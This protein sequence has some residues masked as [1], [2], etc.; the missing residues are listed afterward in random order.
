M[1]ANLKFRRILMS[2]I[3]LLTACS[4]SYAETAVFRCS[5]DSVTGQ[6]VDSVTGAPLKNATVVAVWKIAFAS[7]GG[8]TTSGTAQIKIAKT[9]VSGNFVID[10][11]EGRVLT[12]FES[13]E[14]P[15]FMVLKQDYQTLTFDFADFQ[16]L[17]NIQLSYK[18][19]MDNFGKKDP[20]LREW[21]DTVDDQIQKAKNVGYRDQIRAIFE[22]KKLNSVYYSG[23]F[24][25]SKVISKEPWNLLSEDR[26]ISMLL[27]D[28]YGH[29][30]M[31]DDPSIA[32]S[33]FSADIYTEQEEVI[34]MYEMFAKSPGEEKM[35]KYMDYKKDRISKY[36]TWMGNASQVAEEVAKQNARHKSWRKELEFLKTEIEKSSVSSKAIKKKINLL[37]VSNDF[38]FDNKFIH[39]PNILSTTGNPTLFRRL[40]HVG[41]DVNARFE[42]DYA[43]NTTPLMVQ[44][45]NGNLRCVQILL[46]EGAD[47]NAV[48]AFGES[49]LFYATNLGSYNISI[50]AALLDAGAD[51]SLETIRGDKAVVPTEKLNAFY[52]ESAESKKIDLGDNVEVGSITFMREKIKRDV[53]SFLPPKNEIIEVS[54]ISKVEL[55]KKLTEYHDDVVVLNFF[56][57]SELKKGK[58]GR[59]EFLFNY[60][61]E[62]LDKVYHQYENS[63]VKVIGLV[64]DE[65]YDECFQALLYWKKIKYPLYLLIDDK[66]A[67]EKKY[68]MDKPVYALYKGKTIENGNLIGVEDIVE[69]ILPSKMAKW[70]ALV[71]SFPEKSSYEKIVAVIVDPQASVSD[72]QY[73]LESINGKNPGT[74][75]RKRARRSRN[76]ADALAEMNRRASEA[77]ARDMATAARRLKRGTR[78]S[79]N[80]SQSNNVFDQIEDPTLLNKAILDILQNESHAGLRR[81]AASV[82]ASLANHLS[83]DNLKQ[84]LEDESDVDVFIILCNVLLKKDS[85][86]T[87]NYLIKLFADSDRI[88]KIHLLGCF[89]KA[90]QADI[91]KNNPDF[92]ITQVT[93]LWN[94]LISA[95]IK[96]MEAAKAEKKFIEYA[97]NI[98]E[99]VADPKMIP[100]HLVLL[101]GYKEKQNAVDSMI[102]KYKYLTGGYR[103]RLESV[104]KDRSRSVADNAERFL[105]YPI[106]SYKVSNPSTIDGEIEIILRSF[107]KYSAEGITASGYKDKL[108]ESLVN[109]LNADYNPIVKSR[110]ISLFKVMG[111]K[112]DISYLKSFLKHDKPLVRN[113]ALVPQAARDAIQAITGEGTQK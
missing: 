54:E 24:K 109:I 65:N 68:N 27:S 69:D 14:L 59:K 85:P 104:L 34:P 82:L 88:K 36:K 37:G 101:D 80:K 81:A 56:K 83:V 71:K 107:V 112:S 16:S 79:A 50:I 52:A 102:H 2:L 53:G 76:P 23:V 9:D 7:L 98:C 47:V 33:H 21:L 17:H 20:A 18:A 75:N 97:R 63:D 42:Y 103:N 78:S 51:E 22:K 58:E 62:Y 84:L 3:I 61:L 74:A 55:T 86:E 87:N 66:E 94:A 12:P 30:Y 5:S 105:Y 57:I 15:V 110:A 92:F 108:R 77:A 6:I 45:G 46:S 49:A 32:K 111:N 106:K 28:I 89:I 72:R 39:Q 48:N 11:W 90:N 113:E 67:V 64:R 43:D 70:D 25:L 91:I 44:A 41:A 35:A 4:V 10:K 60:M 19:V 29:S 73:L 95:D 93:Q 99:V 40:I 26:T 1:L 8:R 31:S 38:P 96:S 13:L 100:F